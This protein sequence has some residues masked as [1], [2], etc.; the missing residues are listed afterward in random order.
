M[1][2]VKDPV[3]GMTVKDP[4]TAPT[5]SHD[6]AD[7]HFCCQGCAN[8]F[9]AAPDGY[10]AGRQSPPPEPIPGARYFCPM[11]E[12]VESDEPAACPKCGMALEAEAPLSLT[13]TRPGPSPSC[14]RR[15]LSLQARHATPGAEKSAP[16][17]SE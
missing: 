1:P 17:Q 3:C 8:K 16:L 11:C 15:G 7:Y 5:V 2:E 14:R 6:G 10:L 12:G 13:A 9:A 4:V